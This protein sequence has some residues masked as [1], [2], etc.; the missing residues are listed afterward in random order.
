M[1]TS[2]TVKAH[3]KQ[4][5]N[6]F[7]DQKAKQFLSDKNIFHQTWAKTLKSTW[8]LLKNK[9]FGET[10]T[11]LKV[12]KGR[13]KLSNF[14]KNRLKVI[15]V[16]KMQNKFLSIKNISFSQ[17][18]TQNASN[19]LKLAEKQAIRP[20]NKK[21]LSVCQKLA[22]NTQ[23]RLEMIFMPK[24]QKKLATSWRPSWGLPMGAKS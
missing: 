6:S 4:L 5:G 16:T 10:A 3:W 13:W 15:V 17:I 9:Q 18:L 21:K 14:T 1:K 8:N 23:N 22:K 19:Q 20:N 11:K 24:D 7:H 2:K 12:G